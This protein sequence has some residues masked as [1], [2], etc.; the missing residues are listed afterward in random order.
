ME[1]ELLSD[2]ILTS[3]VYM[4]GVLRRL[5]M[6]QSYQSTVSSTDN[7]LCRSKQGFVEIGF[8]RHSGVQ[9]FLWK[10]GKTS[11]VRLKKMILV[12]KYGS[13]IVKSEHV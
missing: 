1:V 3:P 11:T 4:L 12:L 13:Q 5:L 6:H 7:S 10:E 2:R 9:D 8:G